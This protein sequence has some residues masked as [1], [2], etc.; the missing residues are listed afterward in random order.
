MLKKNCRIGSRS[1]VIPG[2]TIGKNSIVG[3]FSFVNKDIPANV[4]AAGVPA[5]VIKKIDN[6]HD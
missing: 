1:V 2:M 3:A 4:V 5:K 6:Q